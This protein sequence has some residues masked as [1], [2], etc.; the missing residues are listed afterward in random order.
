MDKSYPSSR[1]IERAVVGTMLNFPE[2][3]IGMVAQFGGAEL[4]T[5]LEHIAIFKALDYLNDHGEPVDLLTV[6]DRL[7][8][9][10]AIC[11]AGGEGTIVALMSEAVTSASIKRH[12]EILRDKTLLRKVITVMKTVE[13]RCYDASADS[14]LIMDYLRG[15]N[16]EL[17]EFEDKKG[18]TLTEQIREWVL[19]TNGVFLVTDIHKELQLMTVRDKNTGGHRIPLSRSSHGPRH[20]DGG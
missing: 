9:D 5:A 12:I 2:E 3:T 11:T 16:Q 20:S 17:R 10:N 6:I 19:M 4:F 14:G 8:K 18:G 1:D 15:S 7:E 13:N